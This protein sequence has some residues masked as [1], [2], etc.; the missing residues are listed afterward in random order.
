MDSRWFGRS[1]GEAGSAMEVHMS[2]PPIKIGF[3]SRIALVAVLG[4]ALAAASFAALSPAGRHPASPPSDPGAGRFVELAPADLATVEAG[5][6]RLSL[7]ITGTL[8]PTQE[9]RVKAKVAGEIREVAVREGETVQAG[10]VL[11]R[12]DAVELEARLRQ[13]GAELDLSRAQAAQAERN[14]DMHRGLVGKGFVSRQAYDNARSAFEAGAASLRAQRAQVELAR[15]ALADALVRA[16]LDGVVAQRFV[17]VGDKAAVD[18]P[19][20][21]IVNLAHME[22]EAA[23][24]ASEIPRVHP[25]QEVRFGVEGFEG[26]E[27]TGAVQRI[28][29]TARDGS[30][31][32]LV[33][34]AVANPDAALKGGMFAKGSLTLAQFIATA[35]IPRQAL[36]QDNGQAYVYLF[37]ST[38]NRASHDNERRSRHARFPNPDLPGGE[39]DKAAATFTLE[40]GAL[41]RQAVLPGVAGDAQERVEI[42]QGLE[43][44]QRVVRA[45][46][47]EFADGVKVRLVGAG[48]AFGLAAAPAVPTGQGGR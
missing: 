37:T 20:F 34:I 19:L 23:V 9:S 46:L 22:V 41:L 25:D 13:H 47:G 11:A 7:P 45:D 2:F 18:S 31:S 10:Q 43:P 21:T 8:R 16:P 39:G 24:P 4:V 5:A 44:G 35:T 17:Q 14:F 36:R 1:S 15:A 32:I 38:A 3:A 26:R 40:D 6:L 28:N 27:F 42:L 12:I 48:P 29:P 30:R 33:H